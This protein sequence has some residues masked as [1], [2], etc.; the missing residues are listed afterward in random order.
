M[1]TD[2]VGLPVLFNANEGKIFCCGNMCWVNHFILSLSVTVFSC[3]SLL[4]WLNVE[5]VEHHCVD[6]MVEVIK[7]CE[8]ILLIWHFLSTNYRWV[9]LHGFSRTFSFVFYQDLF[10]P[11]GFIWKIKLLKFVW[12]CTFL[13]TWWMNVSLL[14]NMDFL[15]VTD[16]CCHVKNNAS[17]SSWSV[18]TLLSFKGWEI[19]FACLIHFH[20]MAL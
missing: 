2:A 5:E 4:I 8:S 17:W 3:F 18:N 11:S 15:R 7:H 6:V 12:D 9:L 20:L 16:L 14:N 19:S 10:I 1:F 13:W